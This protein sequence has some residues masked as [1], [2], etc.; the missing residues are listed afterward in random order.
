MHTYQ[1]LVSHIRSH[2]PLAELLENYSVRESLSADSDPL[3]HTV[4]PQLLQDQVSIQ[5]PC[6]SRE[7]MFYYTGIYEGTTH[8]HS[9][10]VNGCQ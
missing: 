6:L 5:L 8:A 10:K 1:R 2:S 4:T 3:Q 7:G 9:S